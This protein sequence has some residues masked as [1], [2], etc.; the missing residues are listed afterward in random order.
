[1][2]ITWG[3]VLFIFIIIA[4]IIG[5]WLFN[6]WRQGKEIKMPR[7]D[8]YRKKPDDGTVLCFNIYPDCYKVETMLKES[9]SKK[10]RRCNINGKKG[11][12]QKY[13]NRQYSPYIITDTVLY[14]ADR[15][16][17]MIGCKDLRELKSLKFSWFE[18]IAPF[19]PVIALLIGV[20][21]FVI[22]LG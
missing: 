9:T 1:M 22:V 20:I 11:I 16:A 10:A 19:A 14:P 21:L 17:R 13:D 12:M 8:F 2:Q 5:I 3:G 4:V 7:M 15:A 6:N 18:N